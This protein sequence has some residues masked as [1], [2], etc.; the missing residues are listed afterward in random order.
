[1]LSYAVVPKELWA[2]GLGGFAASSGQTVMVPEGVTL[3]TYMFFHGDIFH[4]TGNM[5]F[6]WVFGD[7]VEDAMGHARFVAFYL[8]CGVVA[9]L[10]HAAMTGDVGVPLIGASGAVAGCIAAYLMLHPHMRV[11]ILIL[12]FIPVRI[13]AMLALGAWA[14]TQVIMVILPQTTPV[15]WWAHIG[16][17]AAGAVGVIVLRRPGVQLFGRPA[18]A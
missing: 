18:P 12:R 3:L 13:S 15:A 4:I 11:W 5:L 6:L 1:M 9:G 16:G 14:A 2:A 7:N 17:L 8:F 10:T